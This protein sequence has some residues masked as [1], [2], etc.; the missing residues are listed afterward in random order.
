MT[1]TATGSRQGYSPLNPLK[2]NQ[3]NC[4]CVRDFCGVKNFWLFGVFDGHGANGHLV[5]G[6]LKRYLPRTS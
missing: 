2:I 4:A 3:D 5:S 1:R 6:Y